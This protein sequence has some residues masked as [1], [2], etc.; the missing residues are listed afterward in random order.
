VHFS[1]NPSQIPS[2]RPLRLEIRLDDL[3]PLGVEV[4]FSGVT[5]DMGY[6]RV[7]LNAVGPGQYQGQ[8]MLPACGGSRSMTWEAKIM[9][10]TADGYLIAPFRFDA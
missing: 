9:L 5:M 3:D 1:I 2:A 10:E 8:G 6:N 7:R 4:D